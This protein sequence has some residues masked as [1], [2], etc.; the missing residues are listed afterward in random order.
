MTKGSFEEMNCPIAQTLQVVGEWWSLLIVRNAFCGMRHFD[1]FQQH[2]GISSNILSARLAHLTQNGILQRSEA[3]DDRRKVCYR[4]T[5]KGEALY[6][7]LIAMT[8]WGERWQP[9]ED[10]PRLVLTERATGL[11]VAGVAAISVDGRPLSL[12]ALELQAGPGA[13][14]RTQML[15]EAR[16]TAQANQ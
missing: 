5:E 13:D 9:G 6:P 10:G 7:I 1:E 14:Q 2:L 8:A 11:A 4:L 3:Q 15:V 16:L 12:D